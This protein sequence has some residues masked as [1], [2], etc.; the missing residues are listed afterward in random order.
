MK[1]FIF[2]VLICGLILSATACGGDTEGESNSNS[3]SV[4]TSSQAPEETDECAEA[5]ALIKEAKFK[6]A[7]KL[8]LSM[9]DSDRAA[10]LLSGFSIK[11][12]NL[13]ITDPDGVGDSYEFSYNSFGEKMKE[14]VNGTVILENSFDV[15]GNILSSTSVSK[16]ERVV[17]EHTYEDNVLVKTIEKKG[18]AL[19][20]TITYT[21]S[22][23]K[24]STETYTFANG[25][26]IKVEYSYNS[27]GKE[28]S[29]KTTFSDGKTEEI[30]YEYDSNGRTSKVSIITSS[31]NETIQYTYDADG[32]EANVVYSENGSAVLTKVHTYTDGRLTKTATKKAGQSAF[33]TTDYS[34]DA[35]GNLVKEVCTDSDYVL[36][37]DYT[38]D[39]DGNLIKRNR[40]K[41][42]TGG[43]TDV[44][45]YEY[46]NYGYYFLEPAL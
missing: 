40:S 9:K 3:Q 12:S 38:Y 20:C 37:I 29:E 45:I 31:K 24:L 25:D 32:N 43:E 8:L 2:V 42:F 44:T 16:G 21:Y 10:E 27:D 7:Y 23:K 6:E 30:L 35:N 17:A 11:A 28:T 22:D 34:Y 33:I 5:V 13:K 18:D 46:S 15:N 36:T 26:I 14:T 19:Y 4:N 39:A 1:R 41:A